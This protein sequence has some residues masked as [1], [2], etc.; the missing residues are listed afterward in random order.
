M[1]QGP[2]SIPTETVRDDPHLNPYP[3]FTVHREAAKRTFPWEL[4]EDEIQLALP[5][6]QDEEED[7]YT[8]ETKRPRLEEPIPTSTDEA[9]TEKTS[10]DTTVALPPPEAAAAAATDR[11][12]LD[13]VTDTHPIARTTR[14]T[15]RWTPAENAKLTSAITD[16]C[17]K[18]WGKEFKSD[19]D[20]ISALVPGRTKAQCYYRWSNTLVS[21][22]DRA[23]GRA[24]KWEDDEDIKLRNAVRIHGGKNWVAIAALVPGRTECQCGGRWRKHLDPDRSTVREE[25]HDTVNKASAS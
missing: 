1:Q 17:K 24:G 3:T 16:T 14:A 19:W 11:D 20:A 22:S 7:N 5:R 12:D 25:E 8:R 10:H 2:P 21:K 9:T 6:T 23:N 13:P 15:R 18:K 4:T